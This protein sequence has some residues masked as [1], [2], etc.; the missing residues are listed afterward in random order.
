MA[1]SWNLTTP[2]SLL[3]T[4]AHW[5]GLAKLCMDTSNTLNILDNVTYHIG[6][7]FWVFKAKTCA[8]FDTR[9]LDH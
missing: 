4:C 3:F 1:Y 7:E 6:T 2:L 9:E 5:H 8:A